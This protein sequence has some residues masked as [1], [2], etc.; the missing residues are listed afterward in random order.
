MSN[1]ICKIC[2]NSLNNKTHIV[3]ERMLGIRESFNYM[4]CGNCGCLQLSDPPKEMGKYYPTDKYYSFAI[5]S[6]S[7]FK[8]KVKTFMI[9]QLMKYYT[10]ALSVPGYFLSLFY[11]FKKHYGWVKNLKSIP[12]TA[13]ILDIGSGSGK[14]LLELDHIGFHNITG[15][16]PYNSEVLHLNKDII[17][18]NKQLSEI[19]QTFDFIMMNHSLEHI[20]DQHLVF[21]QLFKLL[22]PNGKILIRIPVMGGESWRKYNINWFQIDAPRHYFLHT[23]KSFEILAHKHGFQTQSVDFDSNDYQFIFSEQ[24]TK[25]KIMSDPYFFNKQEIKAFRKRADYLNSINDGDQASFI[26]NKIDMFFR[27]E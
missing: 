18:Y 21:S 6:L 12:T 19:D 9:G 25:N 26:I 14:Y 3:Q 7:P 11:H 2:A 15:I 8:K 10:G 1:L 22:N 23:L 16:D 13:S 17:I 20:E 27:N 24:Y 5:S 4:E